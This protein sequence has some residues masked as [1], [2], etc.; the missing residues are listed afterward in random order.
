MA[1]KTTVSAT[2]CTRPTGRFD[3]AQQAVSS[4]A[5]ATLSQAMALAPGDLIAMGTPAGVGNARTPQV[6]MTAG[7]RFDVDVEGL[8]RLSNPVALEA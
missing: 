7:D 3:C 6:F 8:M 2:P 1:G 4:S 5:V